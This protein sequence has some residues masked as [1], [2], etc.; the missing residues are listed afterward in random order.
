MCGWRN[1]SGTDSVNCTN[2]FNLS[3]WATI[4]RECYER[5][6]QRRDEKS[7]T[8]SYNVLY[9]GKTVEKGTDLGLLIRVSTNRHKSRTY[10]EM[11]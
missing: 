11:Q 10:T 2:C 4:Q 9:D 8:D 7:V 3:T 5:H 1:I 6:E